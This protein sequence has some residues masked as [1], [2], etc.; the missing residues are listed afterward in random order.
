MPALR[1][2]EA[3]AVRLLATNV[4]TEEQLSLLEAL[5]AE[6][7]YE[8]TSVGYFVTLSHP[9]L[10]IV[11]RTLHTPMVIGRSGNTE[12]GFIAYLGDAELVLECHTWGENELPKNFR[13]LDVEITAMDSGGVD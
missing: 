9:L 5:P 2:F 1:K 8:D 7:A 10:P 13:E 11:E 12:C 3:K 6:S 4:L